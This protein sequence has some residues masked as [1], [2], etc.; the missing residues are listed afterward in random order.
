MTKL[1]LNF[2]GMLKRLSCFQMKARQDSIPDKDESVHLQC[3]SY[4][5]SLSCEANK[6]HSAKASKQLSSN[7]DY[8]AITSLRKPTAVSGV[9]FSI[10]QKI[11]AGKRNPELST[12]V[13]IADGFGISISELFREFENAKADERSFSDKGRIRSINKSELTLFMLFFGPE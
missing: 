10:I 4:Q 12:I 1:S 8:R 3:V 7:K 13:A 2:A 11:P 5:I 6:H 9:E